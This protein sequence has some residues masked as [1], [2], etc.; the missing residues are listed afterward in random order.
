MRIQAT[1]PSGSSTPT[2]T[3]IYSHIDYDA[4]SQE[5]RIQGSVFDPLTRV[6]TNYTEYKDFK[7]SKSYMVTS[8]GCTVSQMNEL[9]IP[10]C[11]AANFT[12]DRQYSLGPGVTVTAWEGSYLGSLW[13][14]IH[15]IDF[16]CAPLSVHVYG[17][18][19]D[20]SYLL[21]SYQFG[22]VQLGH[23]SDPA[24]FDLPNSCKQGVQTV[25]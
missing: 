6:I 10:P 24:P 11:V 1:L 12:I 4:D 15:F 21:Y 23:L 18:S 16:N 3:D 20:G 22:D 13:M 19:P 5:E 2:I 7:N 8:A 14:N 17:Q 25:G 9:M